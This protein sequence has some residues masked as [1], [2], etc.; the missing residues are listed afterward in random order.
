VHHAKAGKIGGDQRLFRLGIVLLRPKGGQRGQGRLFGEGV[1]GL[2]PGSGQLGGG[3]RTDAGHQQGLAV[4][5]HSYNRVAAV[6]TILRMIGQQ[7][8]LQQNRAGGPHVI[9]G[10]TVGL[11]EMLIHRIAAGHGDSKG[12][13]GSGGDGVHGGS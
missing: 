5:Q 7:T 3:H 10:E 9:D 2:D 8:P 4:G 6:F 11:A 13:C 12:N 1:G